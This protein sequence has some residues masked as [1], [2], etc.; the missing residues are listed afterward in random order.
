MSE[1][2]TQSETSNETDYTYYDSDNSV[3]NNCFYEPEEPSLTKYNFVVC[4]LYNIPDSGI[5]Y[6]THYRFKK[7]D[8]YEADYITQDILINSRI[9]IAECFYLPSQECVSILKTFWLKIIQRKWKN[10]MRDRENIIRKR[11]H[12]NSLIYREIYGKWPIN[13]S[14]Y[15]SLRGMLAN[16]SRASF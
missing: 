6:L 10:I 7:Y 2:D 8:Y 15:P 3:E 9:E 11:C 1:V 12:P 4:E 16:L 5:Y 13:C 14:Y